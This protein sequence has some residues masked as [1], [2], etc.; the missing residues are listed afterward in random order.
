MRNKTR[1][2]KR[3]LPKFISRYS[4]KKEEVLELQK[5]KRMNLYN[6]EIRN[7]LLNI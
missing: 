6:L 7:L 1:L 4:G 3:F 5:I 2:A